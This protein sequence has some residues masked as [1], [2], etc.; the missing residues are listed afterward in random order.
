MRSWADAARILLVDGATDQRQSL[1]QLIGAQPDFELIG[2]AASIA[3]AERLA[4]SMSPEMIVAEVDLPDA[5]AAAGVARLRAAFPNSRLVALSHRDSAREIRAAL[6]QGARGYIVKR[7]MSRDLVAG[8]R[9]VASGN[10]H[11]C[12]IATARLRASKPG[13]EFAT[14]STARRKM[15]SREREVLSLVASGKCNKRMA[16]GLHLSVKTV[17][18]HRA[19]LMRKLGL[20]NVADLTRY[21]L[22]NGLVAPAADRRA[23]LSVSPAALRWIPPTSPAKPVAA[24]DAADS[25]CPHVYYVDRRATGR[26]RARAPGLESPGGNPERRARGH[27]RRV[28]DPSA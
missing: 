5:G 8:L 10:R 2:E 24:C 3:D 18:K 23:E 21:A 28:V 17:E 9:A 14:A 16:L 27:G 7:G 13:D 19:N 15:T 12:A 6:R 26:R 1:A 22:S 20:H 25:L 4:S 11:L